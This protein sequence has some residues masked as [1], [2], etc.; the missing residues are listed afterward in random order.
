MRYDRKGEGYAGPRTGPDS[1][2][3][4]SHGKEADLD[5][6]TRSP[7]DRNRCPASARRIARDVEQAPD[8]DQ[9][10]WSCDDTHPTPGTFDQGPGG[11]AHRYEDSDLEHEAKNEVQGVLFHLT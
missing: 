3:H 10:E 4:R 5:S 11:E 2:G 6:K 8:R 7:G 1:E 9:G